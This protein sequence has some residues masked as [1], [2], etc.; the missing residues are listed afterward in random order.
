MAEKLRAKPSRPSR[1]C[2]YGLANDL[3]ST[4]NKEREAYNH[5]NATNETCRKEPRQVQRL[6]FRAC[7]G[8]FEVTPHGRFCT[9]P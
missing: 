6:K 4:V 9:D 2:A 5:K 7:Y 1:K 8:R 3:F